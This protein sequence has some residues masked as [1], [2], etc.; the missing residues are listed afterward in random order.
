LKKQ[1]QHRQR[2]NK[3]KECQKARPGKLQREGK[4]EARQEH[5][6]RTRAYKHDILIFGL[7][8]KTK[9]GHIENA[10]RSLGGHRVVG[11]SKE[12]GEGEGGREEEEKKTQ[13]NLQE[14]T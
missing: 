8:P 4:G 9:K 5:K 1:S 2:Q 14:K 7:V 11:Q 10:L 6:T 12:E 3:T 13:F